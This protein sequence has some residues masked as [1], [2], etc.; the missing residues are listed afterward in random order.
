MDV[1]YFVHPPDVVSI[2]GA[3]VYSA[4]VNRF[5]YGKRVLFLS[6]IDVYI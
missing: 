6:G 2:L 5:L 1:A 4:A 3:I